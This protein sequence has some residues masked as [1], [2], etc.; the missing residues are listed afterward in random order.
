MRASS[1]KALLLIGALVLFVLLFTA[2]KLAE[3][4]EKPAPPRVSGSNNENATLDLYASMASKSIDPALKKRTDLWLKDK[5]FDSLITFWSARKR[6]DLVAF[7]SEELAKVNNKALSWFEAGSRYYYSVQFTQDKTEIPVLYESSMRCLKRS[8]AIDPANQDAKIMLASAI[9]DG[10][11]DPMQGVSLLRE[12]E[13][14]DS[15][16]VKLQLSFAFFSVKS[17]QMDRAVSRFNKVLRID[18]NYIEAYLHL[19]DA[20]ERMNEKDKT[21]QMLEQYAKRTNDITSRVE[22]NSYIQQLKESK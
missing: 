10:T 20:Y 16:N 1:T 3:K 6:A 21:I 9:L 11:D 12:V 14:V 17:G 22:V 5:R 15:N 8:L 13:K 19:A 4:T 2:P 18:S 7:Y